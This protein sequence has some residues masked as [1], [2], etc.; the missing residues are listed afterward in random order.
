MDGKSVEKNILQF[1][2]KANNLEEYF[3]GKYFCIFQTDRETD[4]WK[5]VI[6]TLNQELA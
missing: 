2:C 6:V 1:L 3:C 4:K 5:T